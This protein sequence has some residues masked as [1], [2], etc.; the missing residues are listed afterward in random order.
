MRRVW[1]DVWA[2]RKW[3]KNR[4][5][6]CTSLFLSTYMKGST[7]RFNKYLLFIYITLWEAIFYS[8]LNGWHQMVTVSLWGLEEY[9][10]YGRGKLEPDR[11][12]P[13]PKTPHRG[14]YW[15]F[16]RRVPAHTGGHSWGLRALWA[17]GGCVVTKIVI[18]KHLCLFL[19]RFTSLSPVW[20]LFQYYH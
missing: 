13:A 15:R 11:S 1:S 9:L 12:L 4:V 17:W 18:K 6:H 16:V 7:Y 3:R 19:R 20:T 2:S 10:A 14:T 8:F 5:L